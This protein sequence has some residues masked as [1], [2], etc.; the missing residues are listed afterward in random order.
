MKNRLLILAGSFLLLLA[1]GAWAGSGTGLNVDP[2]GSGDLAPDFTLSEFGTGRQVTL[3]KYIGKKVVMLEFWATWCN[4]CKTEMPT[5]VKE[6]EE[7]KNK[8][9]EVFAITLTQGDPKDLDKIQALKDKHKLSYPILLDTN[10]EV[11]TG[12]YKLTGPIPLKLV[13][14]C[15][16]RLVY[17]HIGD[18]PDGVSEIPFVLEQLIADPACKKN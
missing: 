18:F 16:G 3:S 14:D 4:I 7:W 11:A 1:G 6:Y 12:L 15:K 9:Y 10:Y 8:G 13:I 2:G 5:L 17:E